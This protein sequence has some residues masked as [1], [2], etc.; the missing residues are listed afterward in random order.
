MLIFK[1]RRSDPKLVE[2]N[3]KCGIVEP[4]VTRSI[5]MQLAGPNV[6]FARLLVKMVALHRSDL[7]AS[8][9][10][11]WNL[12][13]EKGVVKKVVDIRN[14]AF[15]GVHAGEDEHDNFSE[16]VASE[17]F[18]DIGS[19]FSAL[20]PTE[21]LSDGE[22]DIMK[23]H[24]HHH[25]PNGHVH[26]QKIPKSEQTMAAA[27]NDD[28]RSVLSPS[29]EMTDVASDSFKP[30]SATK[31]P[32]SSSPVKISAETRQ[33]ILP[34][35]SIRPFSTKTLNGASD[36]SVI[37]VK[38]GK[39]LTQLDLVP[40]AVTLRAIEIFDSRSVVSAI[41]ITNT[42]T[43]TSLKEVFGGVFDTK[44]GGN[45]VEKMRSVMLETNLRHIMIT[46][47]TL[48]SVDGSI[49]RFAKL[50]SLDLSDNDIQHIGPL[51]LPYLQRL[52]VARNRI[53]SIDF[54]ENLVSLKAVNV[55]NNRVKG[56]SAITSL[57]ALAGTLTNVDF[58][59]NPCASD[60]RYASTV[61]SS[62]PN[63]VIFDSRDLHK[64]GVKGGSYSRYATP[65]SSRRGATTPVSAPPA[66]PSLPSEAKGQRGGDEESKNDAMFE[67]RLKHALHSHR[68]GGV[69]TP[70][71]EGLDAADGVDGLP[72]APGGVPE[73]AFKSA[74][75]R[76]P[77]SAMKPY[78]DRLY[79]ETKSSKLRMR[80]NQHNMLDHWAD[81]RQG[82]RSPPRARSHS[83]SK[84]RGG[85]DP[86]GATDGIAIASADVS[87]LSSHHEGG[88][89]RLS[90]LTQDIQSNRTRRKSFGIVGSPRSPRGDG[91][92]GGTLT[93]PSVTVDDSGYVSDP[94]GGRARRMSTRDMPMPDDTR[95][96]QMQ[97]DPRYSIYHPRYRVP[98]K[99]FGFSKPF[100][101]S[102]A[103][104]DASTSNVPLFDKYV[105]RMRD[106]FQ[107]LPTRGTFGRASKGLPAEWYPM[108]NEDVDA[109]R[110]QGY[111][112]ET[113]GDTQT[114]SYRDLRHN[115][116]AKGKLNE[117]LN[118][119]AV[120]NTGIYEGSVHLSPKN[121]NRRPTIVHHQSRQYRSNHG[122]LDTEPIDDFSDYKK[123][124]PA[125]EMESLV[126]V[127]RRDPALSVSGTQYGSAYEVNK[128]TDSV[129]FSN[130]S[131]DTSAAEQEEK[132]LADYLQWLQT[133]QGGAAAGTGG[134]PQ[135]A[136]PASNNNYP[137]T[138]AGSTAGSP[139]RSVM[140]S[141][142]GDA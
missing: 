77:S 67:R 46:S 105:Q 34:I 26:D 24:H 88:E 142:N 19:P 120:E 102:R 96:T 53:T 41:E 97:Q 4:G 51:K 16:S 78:S 33:A 57:V 21:G 108:D 50:T 28:A 119:T 27:E 70:S 61:I 29:D 137:F 95:F 15:I 126:E 58:S 30:I 13:M 36:S 3:P 69:P 6:T 64:F 65:S 107:K 138:K 132:K 98:K 12:G 38:G 48:C 90:T 10:D 140:E 104:S 11:N 125:K 72:A 60:Q 42:N 86:V 7:R 131:A 112:N 87:A 117:T 124:Y 82:G 71:G 110:R 66:P 45:E 14:K 123:W 49:N 91:E 122:S 76:A 83:P 85:G 59:G 109:I 74:P 17:G 22:D 37:E 56:V 63:L 130:A 8:F 136:A 89:H 23:S 139:P 1:I 118:Q 2:F 127:A 40:S 135:A 133:Q 116:G 103:Q 75:P 81:H 141:K 99:V 68:R 25:S 35:S 129:G 44:Y 43:R 20:S 18:H 113:I 94:S 52:D 93:G 121:N 100:A 115:T 84:K 54:M 134:P 9:Q 31:A 62:F 101:H 55:S 92:E 5:Q 106:G 128:S 39:T 32:G 73:S 47:T 114:N 79:S 80:S 111:F